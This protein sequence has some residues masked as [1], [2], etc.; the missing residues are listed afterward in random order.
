[1]IAGQRSLARCPCRPLRHASPP[2][3]RLISTTGRP[4]C[5][6]PPAW[7]HT[8]PP[9]VPQL[10][11]EELSEEDQKLKEDLELMVTRAADKDAGV[12]KLAIESLCN[13]IRWV[14]RG[15]GVETQRRG[16]R[17]LWRLLWW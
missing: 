14:W 12:Q 2:F 7:P 17:Q 3:P 4:L 6:L 15:G 16:E 13:E 1:M 11:E 5:C 8:R 10:A 9:P